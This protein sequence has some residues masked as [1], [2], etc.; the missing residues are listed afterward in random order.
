MTSTATPLVLLL[1]VAKTEHGTGERNMHHSCGRSPP[2]PSAADSSSSPGGTTI[3]HLSSPV[4]GS[5]SSCCLRELNLAQQSLRGVKNPSDC[6]PSG[7]TA[8]LVAG[9]C[10]APA[11]PSTLQHPPRRS[12]LQESF[13]APPE[14]L[15]LLFLLLTIKAACCSTWAA[16]MSIGV[17]MMCLCSV[18]HSEINGLELPAPLAP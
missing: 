16:K 10:L 5:R 8:G 2:H 9:Q 6:H 18:L 17:G 13:V 4:S 14:F 12:T 11:V 3:S 1:I 15:N 7:V